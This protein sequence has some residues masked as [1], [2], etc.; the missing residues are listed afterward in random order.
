MYLFF[1]TETN[2]LPA[3][4][5]APMS[6]TENWKRVIQLAWAFYDEEKNLIAKEV[7]LIKPTDWEIPNEKFWLDNGYSTEL[8]IKNGI[9]IEEAFNKFMPYLKK[10]KYIVAHNMSFDYNIL[11]CEMIRLKLKSNNKPIKLCTKEASTEFCAIPN[12]YYKGSFKWAK[13]EELHNKLFGKGFEGAHDAM[14]DVMALQ[15][16]FF[17]LVKLKVIKL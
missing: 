10:C 14:N 3:N 8:N 5:K 1:D 11:G 17:E 12:P 2:G 4:Y 16:C 9:P 6:D 15:R 13:L 7:D